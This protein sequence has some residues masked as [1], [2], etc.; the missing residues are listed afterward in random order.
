V[1]AR[2]DSSGDAEEGPRPNGDAVYGDAVCASG[3]CAGPFPWLPWRDASLLAIA[4]NLDASQRARCSSVI[5]AATAAAAGAGCSTGA[6]VFV[7]STS[8]ASSLVGC[9]L[10]TPLCNHAT[11][12]SHWSYRVS[13]P[14]VS[15]QGI[16]GR[17]KKPLSAM[18]PL[19]PV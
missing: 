4:A 19:V 5:C 7:R 9:L 10:E 13:S 8:V 17:V 15:L 11:V 12:K 14:P 18:A 2:S 1:N 3:S 16:T 6:F